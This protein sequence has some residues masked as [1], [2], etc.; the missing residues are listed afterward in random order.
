[1][2]AQDPLEVGQ[3][4]RQAGASVGIVAMVAPAH[5]PKALQLSQWRLQLSQWPNT[6]RRACPGPQGL[7]VWSHNELRDRGRAVRHM[8]SMSRVI[9]CP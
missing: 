8:S 6:L 4:R 2:L 1:M 7:L 3:R 5:L 9:S